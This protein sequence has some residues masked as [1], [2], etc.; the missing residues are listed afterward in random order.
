MGR[1]GNLRWLVTLNTPGTE[2][3]WIF[4]TSESRKCE[5]IPSRVT[6]P[7]FDD[8]RK[9][10]IDCIKYSCAPVSG[11]HENKSPSSRDAWGDLVFLRKVQCELH[12]KEAR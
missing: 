10:G 3:A 5:T 7:F 6:V 11:R 8:D 12:P 9:G 4:A 2:L 1:L